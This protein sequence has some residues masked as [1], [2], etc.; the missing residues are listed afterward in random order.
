MWKILQELLPWFLILLLFSQY[1]IPL[2]FNQQKWWLF[3]LHKKNIEESKNVNTDIS[4]KKEVEETKVIINEV[5]EKVTKVKEKVEGN[6][7]SAEDLKKE[8]DNLI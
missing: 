7:K 1:I 2:I 5:K 4:L 6:F 8:T 3:K